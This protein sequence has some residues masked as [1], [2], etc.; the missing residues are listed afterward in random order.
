MRFVRRKKA[1][2]SGFSTNGNTTIVRTD[3][4]EVLFGNGF[5]PPGPSFGAARGLAQIDL[6][7]AQANGKSV[8]NVY[9]HFSDSGARNIRKEGQ[10]AASIPMQC[11]DIGRPVVVLVGV[12]KCI[13]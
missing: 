3:C 9:L 8:V 5:D 4:T 1:S 6:L 7:V 10:V 13:A 11:A 12:P 2:I